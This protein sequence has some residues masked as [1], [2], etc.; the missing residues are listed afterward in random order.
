MVFMAYEYNEHLTTAII[1]PIQLNQPKN[2]NLDCDFD[3]DWPVPGGILRPMPPPKPTTTGKPMVMPPRRSV[4]TA[5]RRPIAWPQRRHRRHRRQLYANVE[6]ALDSQGFPGNL[7]VLRAI[8]EA[9]S[10]LSPPGVSLVEDLLR[11]IFRYPSED[12]SS[13]LDDYA[14]AYSDETSQC[15]EAYPCPF[16]IVDL[17]LS[18]ESSSSHPM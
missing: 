5:G 13:A 14:A 16:S 11:V 10:V 4:W 18:H 1:K 3:M 9:K 6:R 2:W 12:G 15:D 7:C 8:C 17:L